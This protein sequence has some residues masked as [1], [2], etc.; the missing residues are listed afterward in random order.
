MKRRLP[1]SEL[2]VGA[3]CAAASAGIATKTNNR[4]F[5]M[6][7]LL[8]PGLRDHVD[9]GRLST[10]DYID[11]LPE[12][13]TQIRRVFDGADSEHSVRFRHCCV[14]DIW[15]RDLVSDIYATYISLSSRR[16]VRH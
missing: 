2:P 9:K 4:G 6:F 7:L 12:G 3:D 5:F 15:I 14:V 10:L 13:W 11:G 8:L 16:H 1:F